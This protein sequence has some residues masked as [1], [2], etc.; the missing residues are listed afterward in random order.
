MT[1]LLQLASRGDVEDLNA[2]VEAPE[3]PREAADLQKAARGDAPSG[4]EAARA[5]CCGCGVKAHVVCMSGKHETVSLS[6]SRPHVDKKGV[7]VRG[8]TAAE[9]SPVCDAARCLGAERSPCRWRGR[10]GSA[11]QLAGRPRGGWRPWPPRA[12]S[13]AFP[14]H[15]TPSWPGS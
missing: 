3:L 12:C 2:S 1:G 9:Q 4:T 15:T 13:S 8:E 7:E 5:E 11:A 6:S 10:R 14:A